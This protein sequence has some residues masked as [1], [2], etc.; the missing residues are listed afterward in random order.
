MRIP[1][2]MYHRIAPCPRGTTVPG[3]YVNPGRFRRHAQALAR[4]GFQTVTQAKMADGLA[5]RDELP[6]K[7]IVLTFDDGYHNF[8][9]SAWPVLRDLGM[10][11]TVFVVAGQVAGTNA[12]D[13]RL[14]DVEERLL[15]LEE[16]QSLAKEGIEMGSHTVTH[17]HLDRV[18][19]FDAEREIVESKMI[20]E[21]LLSDSVRSFCYPYGEQTESLRRLVRAAG[22]DS[23]CGT[24]AGLNDSQTDPYQ[25]RRINVRRSTS[26]PLL[27][28]KLAKASRRP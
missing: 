19:P 3:H 7:P 18:T 13:T 10:T 14:G 8:V 16:I 12:W 24:L 27:F 17:A 23:A 25:W 21:E 15:S 4:A 11:A 9:Q 6:P 5:G 22:Y 28:W 1:V 20:L 26:T 2:L